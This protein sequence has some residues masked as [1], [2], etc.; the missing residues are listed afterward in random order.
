[1]GRK[2]SGQRYQLGEEKELIAEALRERKV[3]LGVCLGAQLVAQVLGA[4]VYRNREKEIGW[5][6]VRLTPEAGAGGRDGRRDAGLRASCANAP[7]RALRDSRSHGGSS[8]WVA[9][10]LLCVSRVLKLWGRKS[11]RREKHRRGYPC[12]QITGFNNK[13]QPRGGWLLSMIGRKR[14]ASGRL[15]RRSAPVPVPGARGGLGT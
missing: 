8:E 7:A 12:R 6:P 13:R 4:R 1:M 11:P 10:T 2:V 15:A 5:F 9:A 3:I 14:P